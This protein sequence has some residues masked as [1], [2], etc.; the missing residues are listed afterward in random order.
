[1]KNQIEQNFKNQDTAEKQLNKLTKQAG[2]E[3]RERKQKIMIRHFE[4]IETVI[5]EASSK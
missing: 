2:E 4:K 1:M 5:A 3:A